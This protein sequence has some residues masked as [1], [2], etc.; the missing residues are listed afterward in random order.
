LADYASSKGYDVLATINGGEGFW[1]NA[2]T[3]FAAQ[4]P[5]GTPLASGS[6]QSMAPGWNLIAIGDGRTP[7]QFNSAIG[8]TPPAPGE[9]AA[10][11]TTL[12]AWDGAKANWYFYS[13]SLDAKGGTFLADYITNKGYLDF[14]TK[15]LDPVTGFWVNMP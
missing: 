6:F 2:K 10:N 7:R 4:L 15:V 14:G 5:A 13:P 11:L 3:T 9:I 8:L 1:V 12:W